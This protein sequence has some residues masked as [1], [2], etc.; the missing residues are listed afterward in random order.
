M[1]IK[2]KYKILREVDSSALANVHVNQDCTRKLA[3]KR[4]KF[5][6]KG[7]DNRSYTTNCVNGNIFIKYVS[8]TENY[9]QLPKLGQVKTILHRIT[10]AKVSMITDL[11]CSGA[12]FPTSS[13]LKGKYF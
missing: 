5:R 9:I 2:K 11:E 4:P 6:A 12:S 13:A 8:D 7:K 1:R 10:S 3:Q